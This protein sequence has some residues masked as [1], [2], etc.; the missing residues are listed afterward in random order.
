[1]KTRTVFAATAIAALA[2]TANPA[3]AQDESTTGGVYVSGSVGVV[4][5]D[6]QL[7]NGAN[8]AGAPRRIIT[9]MDK[10]TNYALALGYA[11][12][13][14]NWGRVRLELEFAGQQADLR[15]FRTKTHRGR[16]R[17]RWRMLFGGDGRRSKGSAH[18]R[19]A[20]AGHVAAYRTAI[21][22]I[23]PVIRR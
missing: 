10:G 5:A 18:P 8:A 4:V 9:D 11:T 7:I 2:V 12:K 14:A 17:R 16:E 1:M 22:P 23:M 6:D 19:S 3:F 15:A 20:D 13:D 21:R